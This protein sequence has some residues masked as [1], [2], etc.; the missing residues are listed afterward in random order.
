MLEDILEKCYSEEIVSD[1][2]AEGIKT[3]VLL[4]IEE[5]K[6]MKHFNIKPLIIAAAITATGALSLVTANA[7]TDGAVMEG[8][9][10][11]F[12]FT[13]NG[14]EVEGTITEYVAGDDGNVTEVEFDLPDG[15]EKSGI[16]V[17]VEGDDGDVKIFTG[18]EVVY[19][20]NVK[21]DL[22][23]SEEEGDITIAVVNDEDDVTMFSEDEVGDGENAE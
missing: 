20:D 23:D 19:G 18:D 16:T 4:R 9:K 10:K 8:I 22:P 21:I 12:S 15:A 7:A 17:A 3:A 14:K 11:T 13:V 5:E 2:S 6:P 1:K